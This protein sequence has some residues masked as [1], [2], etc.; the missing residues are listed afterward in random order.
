M[1]ATARNP[2]DQ[3][4]LDELF[5]VKPSDGA[6]LDYIR[7]RVEILTESNRPEH[8]LRVTIL[9]NQLQ[10]IVAEGWEELVWQKS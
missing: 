10:A 5:R 4:Q 7:D 9:L 2:Q 3:A 6:L 1:S 8:D